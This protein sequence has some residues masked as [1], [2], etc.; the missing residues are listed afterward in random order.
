MKA[1]HAADRHSSGGAAVPTS[2]METGVRCHLTE[3]RSTSLERSTTLPVALVRATSSRSTAGQARCSAELVG[4]SLAPTAARAGRP[5]SS[6]PLVVERSTL[7][8][9]AS[10]STRLDS[11]AASAAYTL[12][13]SRTAG[14]ASRGTCD[15]ASAPGTCECSTSTVV[16][17]GRTPTSWP[18]SRTASRVPIAPGFTAPSSAPASAARGDARRSARREPLS[19]PPGTSSASSSATAARSQDQARPSCRGRRRGGRPAG[20][21][22]NARPH[23]KPRPNSRG[24]RRRMRSLDRSRA[25][26]QEV[27]CTT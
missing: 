23:A 22:E 7:S 3:V 4:H 26:R 24:D 11:T 5:T 27:S 9:P 21:A 25:S 1:A 20:S 17:W 2:P 16:A 10:T 15:G 8:P 19:A 13:T 12:P 14:A 18:Q 6:S